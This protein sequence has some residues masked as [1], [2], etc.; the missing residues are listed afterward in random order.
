MRLA[1]THPHPYPHTLTQTHTHARTH[2]RTH[3]HT[4]T[5]TRTHTLTHS[6]CLLTVSVNGQQIPF[7]PYQ[8]QVFSA[9]SV[10]YKGWGCCLLPILTEWGVHTANA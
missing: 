5:H 1:H 6:W 3:T 7:C 10:W 9:V 8:A 4:H 2:P